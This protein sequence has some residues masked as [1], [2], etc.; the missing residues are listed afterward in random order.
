MTKRLYT[1]LGDADICAGHSTSGATHGS[2][3]ALVAQELY[4]GRAID[5]RDAVGRAVLDA[6][7]RV[8]EEQGAKPV[9]LVGDDTAEGICIVDLPVAPL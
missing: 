6:I 9:L 5:Q 4:E 7:H 2:K 3:A 8:G 1:G